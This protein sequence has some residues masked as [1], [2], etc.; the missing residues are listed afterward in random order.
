MKTKFDLNDGIYYAGI[1]LLFI[2]VAL[3][4]SIGHA[5]IT[6]GAIIILVSWINSLVRVWLVKQEGKHVT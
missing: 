4:Y 5:L 6:V 1:V 3:T 2:G